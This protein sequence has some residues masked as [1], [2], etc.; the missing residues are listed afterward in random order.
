MWQTNFMSGGVTHREGRVPSRP[1]L[2][3]QRS[4]TRW[5]ASLPALCCLFLIFRLPS[6]GAP[7]PSVPAL[8]NQI[9]TY[10]V[11][12]IVSDFPTNEDLSTPEA[13]YATCNRVSASGEQS[14]WRQLSV[15]R[16]AER[17]PADAKKIEVRP[18]AAKEWLTAGILEVQVYRGATAMVFV[19]IPHA[20]K[21]IIDIRSFELDDGRWL[22]TG[23][24]IRDSLE[25]ARTLFVR[26]CAYFEAERQR[27]ARPPIANPDEHLRPFVEF[28]KREATDPQEF[29]LQALAKHRVVILGEVHHRPRYWEFNSALVRAKSFP[30]DVSV[31]YMELPSN[32]QALVDHFL[33][34]PKHDPA[35]VMVMLRDN[36]WM[37]WPD[38]PMLDFFRTVWEVNQGLPTAQRLRIVLVDMQRPWKEIKSRGDWRRYDVDRNQLMAQNIVRD[39]GQHEA[40]SRHALF[41]VGYMHAMVNLFRPD[42][43]PM[44]SAGW[45]LRAKLGAESVFAVFPHTVVMSNDGEVNGRIALGLFETAFATLNNKPV[46]FPLDHGPFGEQ[47]FDASLDD[48]TSDS[49][50]NGFHAYL[51]LGPVED[52]VFSPLIHGFYTDEFVKELERR[53][54][55]MLGRD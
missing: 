29:L 53:S 40:D 51:Y 26:R 22:N 43:E 32:D 3:G 30:R 9:R 21:T 31:I 25:E 35:P 11:N 15:K 39:L 37:G 8:T 4:G 36:L 54:R 20:W 16:L 34:A 55:V 38:Q 19:K 12:K 6:N 52:E 48:L 2:F 1:H 13:A 17:L 42:G 27:S 7:Q 28:L 46:A 47:V 18:S 10:A 45:H 5:N 33:A 23:N 14:R 41:I 50:R 49:Y 24:D 44:K